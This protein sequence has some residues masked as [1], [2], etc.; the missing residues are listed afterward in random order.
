M[1]DVVQFI[2]TGGTIDSTTVGQDRD[3]LYE[4]SIV[5]SF[6]KSKNILPN[7]D[8]VELFL[9]DSR[10][11]TGQDRLQILQ[12]IEQSAFQKIIVTHGTF[13]LAETAKYIKINL[14]NKDKTVI[15]TGSVVP[16]SF[17]DSDAPANLDFAIAKAQELTSGVYI[18][19]NNRVFNPEEAIKDEATGKFYSIFDKK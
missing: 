3:L 18:C 7:A 1:A 19:M 14:A 8:F 9:K 6:I 10:D 17:K 12:N 16:L 5:P 4:H 11:V 13:T 2:I 15:F